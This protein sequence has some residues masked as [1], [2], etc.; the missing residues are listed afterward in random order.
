LARNLWKGAISFS[1]IHIPVALQTATRA[2][3][4]DL[5]LLDRRDFSPVGYQRINK[6]TGKV[7]EWKDIVK[8]YAY[9]PGEYVVLTDEDFRQANV[10]ATQTIEIQGFVEAADVP[11]YY[12]DTPYFLAPQP[13]GEKVYALLRDA[14]ER[15]KKI[16]LALAV[17]RTRQYLCALMPIDDALMLNT[18]R[19][20]DE[21]LPHEKFAPKAAAGKAVSAKE[22]TLALRLIDEMSEQWD[23]ARFSDTYRE[24]IL[25]RVKEKV[26]KGQTHELTTPPKRARA[27]AATE[28]ADLSALLQQSLA[29][30]A[31]ASA[32]RGQ[33]GRHATRRARRA[34]GA[35]RRA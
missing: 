4:L 17:I 23:P 27:P 20:S 6:T 32:S 7:V 13:R 30:T 28:L 33:R 8:G 21:I 31:S 26:S 15:S 18:L 3:E 11:P 9:K 16:G 22:M 35:R 10:A 34:T 14:L 24:D 19:Y 12:F 5:D 29:G 2:E 25:K 1:L